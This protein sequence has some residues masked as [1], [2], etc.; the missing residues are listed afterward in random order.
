MQNH[1]FA[2]A[3]GL[4]VASL[5][6]LTDLVTIGMTVLNLPTHTWLYILN[7]TG[8]VLAVSLYLVLRSI[9]MGAAR[10]PVYKTVLALLIA[11]QLFIF[12]LLIVNRFDLIPEFIINVLFIIS[13]LA[14]LGL[15]LLF[16]FLLSRTGQDELKGLSFLKS[17]AV[18]FLLIIAANFFVTLLSRN[19]GAYRNLF[20]IAYQLFDIVADICLILFFVLHLK[21]PVKTG[22][23]Q[24][25]G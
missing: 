21:A 11:L 3:I 12:L 19:I 25:V 23:N 17:Y 2:P 16:S 18:I 24:P 9:I 4:A 5:F 7:F 13:G 10:L 14:M 1:R 8:P 20:I 22:Y 15:F 6:I